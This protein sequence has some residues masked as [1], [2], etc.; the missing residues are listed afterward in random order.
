MGGYDP[1]ICFAYAF[2]QTDVAG[3]VLDVERG[4]LPRAV[5]ATEEP[6]MLGTP[7]GFIS[8]GAHAGSWRPSGG[9]PVARLGG[10]GRLKGGQAEAIESPDVDGS[11]EQRRCL[12]DPLLPRSTRPRRQ[13]PGI[14][15]PGEIE[16]GFGK[17]FTSY[18]TYNNGY[19]V[20]RHLVV[21]CELFSPTKYIVDIEP[22]L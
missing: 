16:V 5:H 11:L 12:T 18:P 15:R 4:H 20:R 14:R 3:W 8:G 9:L 22:I 17:I 7:T 10:N 13:A 1:T 2:H 6:T 21:V 19:L